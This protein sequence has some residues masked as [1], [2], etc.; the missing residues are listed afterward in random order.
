MNDQTTESAQKALRNA[1]EGIYN[2]KALKYPTQVFYSEGKHGV[3]DSLLNCAKAGYQALFMLE[4]ALTRIGAEQG[5]E[6]L[7]KWFLTPSLRATGTTKQGSKV[8]VYAHQPN[9]FSDPVNIRNVV[10]SGKLVNGAGPI[11][12]EEFNRLEALNGNGRVFVIPYE[13]LKQSSSGVIKVDDALEHPQ[14]IP[15]LGGVDKAKAYLAKHREVYGDRI[16]IW[17]TDDLNK[18]DPLG[19][20]LYLSNDYNDGLNGNLSLDY[21]GQVFGVV[22]PEAQ[23]AKNLE[24]KL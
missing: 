22:A 2:Q 11:P 18:K 10:E 24:S 12:Q 1:P 3:S 6:V 5:S 23:V 16:G 9:Y 8:V 14:T 19:R 20:V 13:T 7:T 4:L 21:D 17:H 15:F